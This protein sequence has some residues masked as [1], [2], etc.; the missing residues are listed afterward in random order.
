MGSDDG[1]WGQ[2]RSVDVRRGQQQCSPVVDLQQRQVGLGGNLLLLVLSG[3]RVL[4]GQRLKVSESPTWTDI[5]YWIPDSNMAEQ[6]LFD[7]YK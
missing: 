3:I 4:R 6:R 7:F 1:N 2:Q 5:E